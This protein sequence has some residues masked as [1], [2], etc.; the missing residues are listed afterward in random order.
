MNRFV[1]T[2]V[3]ALLLAAPVVGQGGCTGASRAPE[4]AAA[5]KAPARPKPS[6]A[7]RT[8]LAAAKDLAGRVQGTAGAERATALEAAAR[9]YDRIA[10]DFGAEPAVAAQ[11][12]FAA[13][14]LWRRH[15]SFALAEQ[16]FLAAAKLDA[17]R[18]AQRATLEAADMQRRLDRHE[19]ALATYGQVVAIAPGTTRAQTARLWQGRLLQALGRVDDAITAFRVALESA[20]GP[21]QV[22]DAVNYLARALVEKGDLD[23]AQAAIAHADDVVATAVAADPTEAEALHK[24][25]EELS[26]RRALQR[27]RD[28]QSGAAEDARKL[29]AATGRGG[30]GR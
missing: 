4:A 5:A 25:L 6:D 10:A 18:F 17:P 28:A 21:R 13:G 8:A 29:E 1:M 30:A 27:A 19:E 23:G 14:E 9:A 24:R 2:I 26:A 12:A 3:G 15:G 11:A 7:A 16:G 22:L 20:A